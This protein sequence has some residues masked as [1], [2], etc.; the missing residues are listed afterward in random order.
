MGKV[1]K[2]GKVGGGCGST[3]VGRVLGSYDVP[4]G[5]ESCLGPTCGKW[6]ALSQA[7]K[8]Q[9]LGSREQHVNQAIWRRWSVESGLSRVTAKCYV[10]RPKTVIWRAFIMFRKFMDA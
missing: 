3:S 8:E 2:V 9:K 5:R 6:R 10:A 7:R 4:N 1:G